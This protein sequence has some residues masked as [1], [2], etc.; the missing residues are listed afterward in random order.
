MVAVCLSKDS[1]IDTFAR[2]SRKGPA[3]RDLSVAR[4]PRVLFHLEAA[5]CSAEPMRGV[6]GASWQCMV[7]SFLQVDS[8]TAL[9][10]TRCFPDVPF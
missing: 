10:R 8:K 4:A 2:T 6:G 9:L 5:S 1:A 3:A 7:L